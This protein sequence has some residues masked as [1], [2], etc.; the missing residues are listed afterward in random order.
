MLIYVFQK[1]VLRQLELA[2]RARRRFCSDNHTNAPK[3]AFESSQPFAVPIRPAFVA[4]LSEETI[5]IGE[6]RFLMRH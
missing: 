1:Q 5:P 2:A 3:S 6:F 4:E